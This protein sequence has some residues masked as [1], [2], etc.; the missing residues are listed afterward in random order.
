MVDGSVD[1]LQKEEEK[2]TGRIVQIIDVKDKMNSLSFI[3]D[4]NVCEIGA[5]YTGIVCMES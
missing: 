5:L 2:E 4:I 3:E 1:V